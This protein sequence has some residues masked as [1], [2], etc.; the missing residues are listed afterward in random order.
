ME[1]TNINQLDLNG[2]YTYANYLLWNFEERVELFNGRIMKIGSSPTPIHQKIS[3][4]INQK[5]YPFFEEKKCE[6]FFAPFD[7]LLPNKNG[8][9]ISRKPIA[10]GEMLQ[11]IKFP[12]LRFSTDGLYEF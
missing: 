2:T 5:L 7:V 4:K 1:I 12:D 9:Y 6:L 8:E 10:D 3:R 11:S